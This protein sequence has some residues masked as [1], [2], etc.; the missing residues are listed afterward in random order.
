M[1]ALHL[2]LPA[3]VQRYSVTFGPGGTALHDGA[4]TLAYLRLR[5]LTTTTDELSVVTHGPGSSTFTESTVELLHRWRNK[6]P[7]QPVQPTRKS[8]PGW[9]DR[10]AAETV[11]GDGI[12]PVPVGESV[13]QA[14]FSG[15]STGSIFLLWPGC[16]G[17][18]LKV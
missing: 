12:S 5:P 6:R 3:D 8:R 10:A 2:E 13:G 17:V 15:S 14:H 16:V 18:M 7:T 11:R 4:G 1:D 9:A